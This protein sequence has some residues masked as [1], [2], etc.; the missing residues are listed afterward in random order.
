MVDNTIQQ[1]NSISHRVVLLRHISCACRDQRAGKPTLK[2]VLKVD[3][4]K[5]RRLYG[6]RDPESGVLKL[7]FDLFLVFR[8]Q[9]C[10]CP[11]CALLYPMVNLD[12]VVEASPNMPDTC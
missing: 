1:D 8:S 9:E 7:I 12:E 2:V 10:R 4:W 11:S 5:F 6:L 3:G